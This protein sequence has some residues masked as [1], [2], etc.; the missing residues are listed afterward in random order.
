MK[1]LVILFISFSSILQA[2][3]LYDL[4]SEDGLMLGS[5]YS[6]LGAFSNTSYWYCEKDTVC[7]L[8]TL[9]YYDNNNSSLTLYIDEDKIYSLSPLDCSKNL[10]YDFSLNIGD[11]IVSGQFEGYRLNSISTIELLD[12]SERQ[13]YNF[14][15]EHEPT[16]TQ[17]SIKWVYGIGDIE[18]GFIPFVFSEGA[19]FFKCFSVGNNP[20]LINESYNITCEE[21][22]CFHPNPNFKFEI[23]EFAL[24]T[25]NNSPCLNNLYFWDFGDNNES[26]SAQASHQ[27]EEPGCYELSLGSFSDCTPDTL[28][29]TKLVNV[30]TNN[31]WEEGYSYPL[32]SINIFNINEESEIVFNRDNI[33]RTDDNGNTWSTLPIPDPHFEGSMRNIDDIKFYDESKGILASSDRGGPYGEFK[34]ILYYTEDRGNTWIAGYESKSA[35]INITL[36]KDGLAWS[37]L[38]TNGEAIQTTN[39]GKSWSKMSSPLS[40]GSQDGFREFYFLND[41]TLFSLF[42][43]AFTDQHVGYS[44]NNGLTWITN[45]TPFSP[46]Q[47]QFINEKNA[48][49]RSFFNVFYE[50]KDMGVSWTEVDLP[51]VPVDFTMQSIDKGWFRSDSGILYY[52]TDGLQS[53]HVTHCEDSNISKIQVLNDSQIIGVKVDSPKDFSRTYKETKVI[54]NEDLVGFG[55]CLFT[56]TDKASKDKIKLYPNPTSAFIQIETE[57]NE[58]SIQ[59]YN[60]NGTKVISVENQSKI[61]VR[62]LA[63]GTYF[64]QILD[65]NQRNLSTEKV[66]ILK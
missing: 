49:A 65:S 48:F 24:T 27:Y 21:L 26:N 52:S 5:F 12:N 53:F 3:N 42:S 14:T 34:D 61:D 16:G 35:P 30:C 57:L 37:V 17:K 32:Q 47:V 28:F 43:L 11:T 13:Q 44:N 36:G 10:L 50:T 15:L 58:F 9:K 4:M 7:D 60:I 33:F 45:K 18:R 41:S 66:I 62:Q 51:F 64:L 2:Q 1:K 31:A 38:S 40:N 54:F 29:R 46:S 19:T 22:S 55:G 23:D 25:I 20:L 39:F 6:G 59:V 63:N 8:P 56:S